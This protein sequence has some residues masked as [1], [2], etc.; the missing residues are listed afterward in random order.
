MLMLNSR[1]LYFSAPISPSPPPNINI[2]SGS[3]GSTERLKLAVLTSGGD[4]QGMNA[5]IRSVVRMALA[6]GCIP[7]A[8][9]EGYEGLVQGGSMIVEFNWNNVAQ[10]MPLGGTIIGSARCASFRTREG[11]LK[12]AKNLATLGIHSLVIIGGDGSLTGADILRT[13]WSGLLAELEANGDLPKGTLEQHPVVH[14]AGLVGSIDKDMI[15]TEMTIGADSALHRI[16]EAIDSITTSAY[17]HQRAFIIEVMGRNC[18]WL[19]LAAALASGADW[20]LIPE[21][22]QAVGEWQEVMCNAISRNRSLGKRESIVLLSEGAIDTTGTPITAQM[23]QKCLVERLG[24]DVRATVL[25]HVQRGG[26]PSAY[27]RILATLQGVH[28]VNVLLQGKESKTVNGVATIIGMQGA[29]MCKLPLKECISLTRSIDNAVKRGA[30]DE[31]FSL[32]DKDFH[33]YLSIFKA[34]CPQEMQS[35]GIIP[36]GAP[37]MAVVHV[38]PPCGGMNTATFALVRGAINRGFQ[39]L[40]LIGGW[41]GVTLDAAA[42]SGCTPA[43]PITLLSWM[44]VDGWV[45]E[46]GSHLGTDRSLPEGRLGGIAELFHRHSINSLMIIGGYE[47][48]LS[49]CQLQTAGA[50]YPSLRI[51]MVVV[52]ATISNNVP[53]T[54]VTLGSDTAL[55][56]IVTSCDAIRQSASSSK[57]AFVV[58]VHGGKCGYLSL[59]GGMAAA[60][61]FSYIPEEGISLSDVIRDASHLKHRFM[62]DRRAGRLLLVPERCSPVIPGDILA[63]LLEQEGNGEFDVRVSKLGHLQQG[64]EPSPFDRLLAIRLASLGVDHLASFVQSIA[65]C[66]DAISDEKSTRCS[67]IGLHA[68]AVRLSSLDSLGKIA[69]NANRRTLHPSWMRYRPIAQ[70]LAKYRVNKDALTAALDIP[71]GILPYR[72]PSGV[73]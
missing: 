3:D 53:G 69:D 64:R 21:V 22:P 32:R 71:D 60:A 15:G 31:A 63:G 39:P 45:G 62:D 7:Y 48:Y 35:G 2:N 30:L 9:H 13:E 16:I 72:Q 8:V 34:L 54:D 46:G 41:S 58:E 38:G 18:G 42:T 66:F 28:A 44:D 51:P 6:S 70:L 24:L 52:P 73:N 23:V 36:T 12:A 4:S 1:D 49:L 29:E 56:M 11:R 26:N 43:D 17:S 10:I 65:N 67:L 37:R 5:A 47:A 55:N 50:E 68:G 25:G 20:L 61:T 33:E 57:R 14:I 40:G 19:A 27:D 59:V